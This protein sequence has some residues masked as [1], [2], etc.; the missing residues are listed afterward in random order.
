MIISRAGNIFFKNELY[1]PKTMDNLPIEI[2]ELIALQDH[3]LLLPFGSAFKLVNLLS[4]QVFLKDKFTRMV[5]CY[6]YTKYILPNGQRHREN[7]QPAVIYSN[8]AQE[9]WY[10]GQRHREN[11]KPAI[12]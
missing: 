12:T 9:W 6:K 7:D 11:D 2:L 5:D 1:H 8:G 3:R 4:R 10:N